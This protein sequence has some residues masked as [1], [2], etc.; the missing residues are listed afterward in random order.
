MH[1]TSYAIAGVIVYLVVLA[2]NR[3]LGE[4]NFGSLSDEEKLKLSGEFSIHRSLGTY[5][6]IAI[7]LV[8]MAICYAVP[9][10]TIVI[11]PI[12]ILFI[13]AASVAL[14]FAVFRRLAQLSLPADYISK[15]RT[16]AILAQTGEAISYVL[17]VLAFINMAAYY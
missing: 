11:L 8:A 1:F 6:P 9:Q 7:I 13:L 3:F 17:Y 14:Q 5:I 15:F 12:A 16:Q 10:Y 4:R 2:V